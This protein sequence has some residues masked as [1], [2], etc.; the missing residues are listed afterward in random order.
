MEGL[1]LPEVWKAW[2]NGN[3]TYGGLKAGVAKN[4]VNVI[5]QVSLLMSKLVGIC[6]AFYAVR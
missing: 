5:A 3:R 4:A 2:V 1:S 6:T